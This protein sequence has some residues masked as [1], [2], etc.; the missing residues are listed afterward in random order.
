MFVA[1]DIF[2]ALLGRPLALLLRVIRTLLFR[3]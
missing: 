3:Y 2:A 1:Y